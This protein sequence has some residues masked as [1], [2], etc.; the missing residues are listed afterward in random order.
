MRL[1]F[2]TTEEKAKES[3]ETV[4]VSV[5][6]FKLNKFEQKRE[7]L[8][9]KFIYRAIESHD[10]ETFRKLL[11][12]FSETFPEI[13]ENS[14]CCGSIV[15][16]TSLFDSVASEDRKLPELAQLLKMEEKQKI[17]SKRVFYLE[18]TSANL[19]ILFI[20]LFFVATVLAF[21][22]FVL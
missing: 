15:H 17:L 4:V 13:G 12:S 8:K 18:H 21:R 3:H 19:E 1:I 11:K 16:A 20:F 2:L 14:F 10:R 22:V 6:C 9:E 5:G 7:V